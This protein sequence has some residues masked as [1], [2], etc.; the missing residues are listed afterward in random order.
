MSLTTFLHSHDDISS[1]LV[2]LCINITQS[3]FYHFF[4]VSYLK[5]S[6]TQL[7]NKKT[8]KMFSDCII[9]NNVDPLFGF[10]RQDCKALQ[11]HQTLPISA[12]TTFNIWIQFYFI[13]GHVCVFLSVCT[14]VYFFVSLCIFVEIFVNLCL[15]NCPRSLRPFDYMLCL[16]ERSPKDIRDLPFYCIFYSGFMC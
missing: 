4:N 14:L 10:F 16:N 1:I 3:S 11:N 9:R 15:H 12:K 13:W 8:K 6:I 7:P 5:C 2:Y